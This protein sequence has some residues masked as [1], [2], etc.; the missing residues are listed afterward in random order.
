MNIIPAGTRIY[1]TRVV[2]HKMY[3]R[4]NKTLVDD[5]LYV[6]YDVRLGG[7]TLI[8][9]GTKV[10]GDWVTESD[11]EIAAQLQL[12][13]ILLNPQGPYVPISAASDIIPY[14]RA[15]NLNE[16]EGADYFFL[17][18]DKKIINSTNSLIAQISYKKVSLLNS[19]PNTIYLEIDTRELEVILTDDFAIL[20]FN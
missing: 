12:T 17:L 3:I 15:F 14:S 2:P 16:L 10:V 7:Q 1:L 4:P 8:P 9:R 20:L 13:K 19:K 5:V 6:A 11:P 18:N